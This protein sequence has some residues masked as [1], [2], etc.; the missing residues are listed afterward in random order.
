M[1]LEELKT[2][3]SPRKITLEVSPEAQA[4]LAERG[5]DPL[6]GARP[7]KRAIQNEMANKLAKSLIGGTIPDGAKVRAT[8][9]K[10]NGITFAVS[11]D[12]DKR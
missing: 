7:L 4:F 10:E 6:Y 11:E 12:E 3:L 8:L 2:R 5:Y 1:Q 9:T